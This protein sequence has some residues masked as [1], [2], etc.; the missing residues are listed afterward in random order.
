MIDVRKKASVASGF[1][2]NDGK[3]IPRIGF[4][5]FMLEKGDA[6]KRAVLDALEAGYRHIDCA[7][8]YANE[9]SVGDALRE[10]GIARNEVFVTSK[11][12]NDRQIAG[13]SA[14]RQS[15]EET[16]AALKLDR[17]DLLLIH[18]PVRGKFR[19]TWEQF[20]AMRE[21]GLVTSIGVSNFQREHLDELLSGGD[22]V[23]VVDQVEFHPYLRDTDALAACKERGIVVEAWSPL[24]RGA[25][26]ND[27]KILEIAAAHNADAGQ[28]ILAW[29]VANGI[30][31][32]PRTSKV[33]RMKSNLAS[34]GIELSAEELA[35]IDELN[36][37]QYVI[38]NVDPQHFNESLAGLESPHD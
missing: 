17:L 21:E 3:R 27:E 11:V 13:P 26:V 6:T 19:S 4:G 29:E 14:V 2:M 30:L 38:E 1:E 7:R 35:A 31:P 12:W 25:C 10:A 24:G 15:V 18:W 33:S 23:P 8:L 28:V 20:Q 37:M 5:T 9:A 22:A 36:R 16:L 32:L 34:L